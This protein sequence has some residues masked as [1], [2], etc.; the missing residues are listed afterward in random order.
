MRA[1]RKK[2]AMSMTSALKQAIEESGMTYLEIQRA[3]GVQR[4]SILRFMRG[5]TSIRLD[6]ADKLADY[7]E[8]VVMKRKDE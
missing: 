7:F 5:E 1:A 6:V 8:L 4:A 3:I 2:Q